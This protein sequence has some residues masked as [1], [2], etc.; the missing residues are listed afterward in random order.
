[1]LMSSHQ[2]RRARFVLASLG[3]LLVVGSLIAGWEGGVAI[4]GVAIGPLVIAAYALERRALRKERRE[5]R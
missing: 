2:A 4:E 1:M 5:R 3:I